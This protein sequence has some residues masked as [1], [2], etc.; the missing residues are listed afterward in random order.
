MRK[1][2]KWEIWSANVKFEECCT[3]EERPVLVVSNVIYVMAYKL[4]STD[5]GDSEREYR[6]KD[7]KGAGRK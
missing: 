2:N 5:R 3:I 6:I 7:W 4:T 1:V